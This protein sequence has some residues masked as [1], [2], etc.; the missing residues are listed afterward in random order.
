[1][2][3]A[4]LTEELVEN[5]SLERTDSCTTADHRVMNRTWSERLPL[6][7][8]MIAARPDAPFA[9]AQ[10]LETMCSTAVAAAGRVRRLFGR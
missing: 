6:C 7:D 9:H 10:R 8:R 1:M 4:S 3:A 2:L 5:A